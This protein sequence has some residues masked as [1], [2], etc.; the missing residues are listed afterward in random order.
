MEPITH[1]RN[2]RF[3]LRWL[4][5]IFPVIGLVAGILVRWIE[6]ESDKGWSVARLEQDIQSQNPPISDRLTAEAWFTAHGIDYR[7]FPDP[8][9]GYQVGGRD[10]TT[11][12]GLNPKNISGVVRASIS[13]DAANLGLFTSGRI[14]VFFFIDQDG[15]CSGHWIEPL[16]YTF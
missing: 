6:R 12:A 13:G 15:H 4:L 8:T 16:E 14:T 7:Y 11:I 9:G 5:V 2:F 3:S 1:N 10:I